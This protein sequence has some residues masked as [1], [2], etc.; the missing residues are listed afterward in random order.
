MTYNNRV[1]SDAIA[2]SDRKNMWKWLRR[3]LV[4]V[5]TAPIVVILAWYAVS[6]LP[7]L[8]EIKTIGKEGEIMVSTASD[9]LYALTIAS[10]SKEHIRS[11]A[12]SQVYY[13]LVFEKRRGNNLSWHLNN[14]L[15]RIASYIHF[16]DKETFGI[17]AFYAPYERGLGLNNAAEFYFHKPLSRLDERECAALISAARSPSHYRP[18]S[19]PSEQRIDLILNKANKL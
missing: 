1:D 17:W 16:T 14:L 10:E 8:S 7:Y 19:K 13:A 11:F 9:R 5:I 3:I 15:W 6:F 12:L 2:I 4:I 18:G